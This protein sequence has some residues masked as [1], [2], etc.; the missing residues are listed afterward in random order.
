VKPPLPAGLAGPACFPV[1]PR[2][3]VRVTGPDRVRYLNGQ[4]TRNAASINPR[5]ALPALL[6]TAKGKIVAPVFAWSEGDAILLDS[7][8]A[9]GEALLARVS[10]YAVADDVEFEDVSRDSCGWHVVGEIEGDPPG[11]LVPRTGLPGRDVPDQPAAFPVLPPAQIECLRILA[12]TPE[13][14][15]ELDPDTLPHEA[16]M[17]RHWVDFHKGCY[18]GQEVV[19]RVE[20]VGRTNRILRV[21][22][23]D[24]PPQ[25]GLLLAAPD[26]APAG[27]L[28][29]AA[30]HFGLAGSAGLG[31]LNR[32]AEATR[33]QVHDSTGKTLGECQIHENS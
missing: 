19:S 10:R 15:A 30:P 4:L 26:G 14:G 28:T 25:P 20:S 21:F 16:G 33:F 1:G 32:R 8:P 6:L 17:D 22:L 27:T 2:T 23:G 31:Y 9:I 13:W 24:F 7:H 5:E 12:G 11:L 18:V 29:S 3:R